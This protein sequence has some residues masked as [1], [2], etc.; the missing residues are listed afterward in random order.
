MQINFLLQS[1]LEILKMGLLIPEHNAYVL[2]NCIPSL[3]AGLVLMAA[4]PCQTT[5]KD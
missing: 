1:E 2:E 3:K 5:L 4:V